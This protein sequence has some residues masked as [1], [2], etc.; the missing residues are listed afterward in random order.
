[1]LIGFATDKG[2]SRASNQDAGYASA[3][4]RLLAVADGL[5]GHSGGAE[6]S[7]IAVSSLL[8]S[9]SDQKV[10]L[11]SLGAMLEEANRKIIEVAGEV[12][13]LAGMGTTMTVAFIREGKA[14]I[15]HVGDSRAYLVREGEA[16]RLTSDHSLAG[17]LL[18]SGV[19]KAEDVSGHPGRH[20]VI[21]CLGA[22]DKLEPELVEVAL[23]PDDVLVLC[24]DGFW[25]QINDL[26]IAERF[27]Q[28]ADMMTVCEDMTRL[29]N[30]RGGGDNITVVAAL[31]EESDVR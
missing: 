8:A 17:Q 13:E 6:A 7:N 30:I 5:G 25:D 9:A 4:D 10:E 1:M 23:M 27:S 31:L 22:C 18:S 29:A 16:R 20:A 21:K 19:L 24:T 2:K 11:Q 28:T 26:E 12:P 15:G 14:L 3:E